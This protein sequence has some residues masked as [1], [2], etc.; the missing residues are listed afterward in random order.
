MLLGI[1]LGTIIG[2][3]KIIRKI[4]TPIQHIAIAVLILSMGISLGSSSTFLQ[5]LNELGFKSVVF[6]VLTV[7]FS[8]LC[9][10]VL[11]FKIKPTKKLEEEDTQ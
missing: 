2:N 10:Y 8:I 11:T 9:V 5:D 1:G 7:L 3:F 4:N 6:G